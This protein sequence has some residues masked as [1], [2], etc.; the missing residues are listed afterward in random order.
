MEELTV[1]EIKIKDNIKLYNLEFKK[2]FFNYISNLNNFNKEYYELNSF[3]DCELYNFSRIFE[4]NLKLSHIYNKI[5]N[6]NKIND[7]KNI[8]KISS[9]NCRHLFHDEKWIKFEKNNFICDI[10]D[11]Y[12]EIYCNT[13][14]ISDMK[15]TNFLDFVAN[16]EK[17][18][19]NLKYVNFD[20]NDKN[21]EDNENNYLLM[22]IIL[23]VE[24]K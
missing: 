16:I 23:T 8:L 5:N 18:G 6:L 24:K 3:D 14:N 4:N 13:I 1:N 22:W 10:E 15:T 2:H 20:E 7:I 19:Y 11:D 17:C 12:K 9:F 21:D